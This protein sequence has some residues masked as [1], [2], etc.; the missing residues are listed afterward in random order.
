LEN[1][2]P[3]EKPAKPADLEIKDAALIFNSVWQDL[4]RELGRDAL[5]FPHEIIWLGGAPGAGKGTNTPFILETRGITA[6]PIVTSS[7]LQSEAAQKIKDAGGLVGDE[8]VMG[9]MLRA[10]LQPEFERGIVVDGFPRTK[11]QVE[12]LKMFHDMMIKLHD[13]YHDGPLADKFR[14]PMF[15]IALLFVGE[16]DS[17]QRQLKRG[18]EIA[19]HNARVM[20]TGRGELK[21]LRA[22]DLDPISCQRR[23][24]VFKDTTFEALQSLRE[25][26]HFHFIDAKGTIEEVEK[27]IHKEFQYQSTLELE[28]TTFARIRSLPLASEIIQY[29]RQDLVIRLDTYEEDH[30]ELFG[31]VINL[32][33]DRFVPIIRRHAMTGRA[34]VNSENAIFENRLALKMLIDVFAERGYQAVADLRVVD[35]PDRIDP[36]TH[37]IICRPKHVYTFDILFEPST[38]RRG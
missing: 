36:E 27:N 35:V 5:R 38:I 17:V 18:R 21:E 15:R 37:K 1:P 19:E 26:F 16:E 7:L 34:R 8:E 2:P 14:R 32:I 24:K 25:L 9:I 13:E 23:Y 28:S 30:S 3:P 20:E 12:C 22:T 29:A 10:L 31:E 11:V 4:E 33:G 6:E